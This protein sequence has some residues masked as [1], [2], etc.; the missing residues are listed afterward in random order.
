MELK[1]TAELMLS[2]DY[3]ERFKAEYA[4]EVIRAAKLENMLHAYEDN[5]LTF[6]PKCP[7][8]LLYGQ[9]VYM[10]NKLRIL[11]ERAKIEGIELVV[12][13]KRG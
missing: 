4:Q 13:L 2:D 11:S 5:K 8:E 3:K 10:R 12:D 9:L 6:K 7:Y 1:D